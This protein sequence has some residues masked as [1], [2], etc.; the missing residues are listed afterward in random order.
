[1]VPFVLITYQ[2]QLKTME[3]NEFYLIFTMRDMYINSNLDPLTKFR[4]RSRSTNLKIF[5]GT[6][7]R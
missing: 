6:S 4:A 3:M 7:F 5:Y 2:F 1:M